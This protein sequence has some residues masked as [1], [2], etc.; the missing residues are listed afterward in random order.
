ME[1]AVKS[2]SP[3]VVDSKTINSIVEKFNSVIS[4]GSSSTE[5]VKL[6]ESVYFLANPEAIN[7][8]LTEHIYEESLCMRSNLTGDKI[9]IGTTN[10]NKNLYI[11]LYNETYNRN[12]QFI[13]ENY[14]EE[15]HVV[16]KTLNLLFSALTQQIP[17]PLFVFT[18]I[19][20]YLYKFLSAKGMEKNE[21]QQF[22]GFNYASN[23]NGYSN[24]GNSGS[25]TGSGSSTGS[26]S[27]SRSG[28]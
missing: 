14:T 18:E 23:S 24:S 19:S 26:G 4:K 8:F 11:C 12:W 21:I 7:E 17:E 10:S 16:G 20:G 15:Q 9:I 13:I 2:K 3:N 25:N 5:P 27:T 22:I 6:Y 28:Q 1:T